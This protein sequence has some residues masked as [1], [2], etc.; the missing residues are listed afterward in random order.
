MHP[1]LEWFNPLIRT[2]NHV[3]VKF[4]LLVVLCSNPGLDLNLK[5]DEILWKSFT[6]SSYLSLNA[7]IKSSSEAPTTI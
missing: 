2:T 6:W 5:S 7:L 4:K 1:R 3:F